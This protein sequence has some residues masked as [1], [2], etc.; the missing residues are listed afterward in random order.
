MSTS[1][2]THFEIHATCQS[3][4]NRFDGVQLSAVSSVKNVDFAYVSAIRPKLSPFI[5]AQITIQGANLGTATE[6]SVGGVIVNGPPIWRTVLYNHS[7]ELLEEIRFDDK[8][9]Q[10]WSAA[11]SQRLQRSQRR[12]PAVS[13]GGGARSGSSQQ[14]LTTQVVNRA[15]EQWWEE[16]LAE[17]ARW[18]GTSGAPEF[19]PAETYNFS[20]S[21]TTFI[22]VIFA[23]WF[24]HLVQLQF[25][26]S[27]GQRG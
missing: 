16:L 23:D 18:N 15:S 27:S 21:N 3:A 19:L 10:L 1:S 14:N 2:D 20:S 9:A 17:E 6:V 22:Q 4:D 26:C 8:S 12:K 24:L 25:C 13:V 5:G 7:A 11:A